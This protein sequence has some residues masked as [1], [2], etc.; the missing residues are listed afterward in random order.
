MTSQH[1]SQP[2]EFD[3]SCRC[4]A[5]PP[6]AAAPSPGPRPGRSSAPGARP[7]PRP[8]RSSS[9]DPRWSGRWPS[10][11]QKPVE[12]TGAAMPRDDE[13]CENRS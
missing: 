11:P 5:S 13:N 10:P 2:P 7:R 9:G 8:A 1:R 6:P 3:V 4:V 12:T